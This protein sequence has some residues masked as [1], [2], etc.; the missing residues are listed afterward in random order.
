MGARFATDLAALLAGAFLLAASL[1]FSAP[2]V[3]WIAL[4]TGAALALTV[5]ATFPLRGRGPAQRGFDVCLFLAAAWCLVQSRCFAGSVVRWLTFADGALVALLA[6]AA[7]VVHE[8]QLELALKARRRPPAAGD[9]ELAA[10]RAA[11]EPIGA[12]R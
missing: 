2:V 3:G 11:H 12:A 4:G 1:G 7:L 10:L 5:L 9:G 8:V 6:F